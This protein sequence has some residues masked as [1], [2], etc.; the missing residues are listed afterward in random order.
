MDLIVSTGEQ[1]VHVSSLPLET[2]FRRSE[3]SR[4]EFLLS[5]T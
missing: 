3:I 5:H 1:D 4:F 2:E